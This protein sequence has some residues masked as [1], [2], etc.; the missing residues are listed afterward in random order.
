MLSTAECVF[1]QS[2]LYYSTSLFQFQVQVMCAFR[3][4]LLGDV[5]LCFGAS[6]LSSGAPP[7]VGRLQC[8]T[9]IFPG[10]CRLR[11]YAHALLLR[12]R[13]PRLKDHCAVVC[14]SMVIRKWPDTTLVHT[15]IHRL[16]TCSRTPCLSCN[17]RSS[18]ASPALPFESFCF[19][20]PPFVFL[21]SRAHSTTA[22]SYFMETMGCQMNVADSE[23]M[24]GQMADLG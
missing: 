8:S 16:D 21:F 20:L 13:A 9:C 15:K 6:V 14:F 2:H 19:P 3:F 22:L 10:P 23:R 5:F 18:V 4:D 11:D 17:A 12:L 7:R 24:E 1:F